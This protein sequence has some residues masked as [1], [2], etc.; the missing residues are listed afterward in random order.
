VCFRIHYS[1]HPTL[2]VL[3][4]VISVTVQ[5]DSAGASIKN[6]GHKI[7]SFSFAPLCASHILL[8]ALLFP[9]KTNM[10]E[11]DATAHSTEIGN[12]TAWKNSGGG[13]FAF[14]K[15]GPTENM[16]LRFERVRANKGVLLS[17]PSHPQ[18]CL[19]FSAL[20]QLKC[21]MQKGY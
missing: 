5:K 21:L 16:K 3:Y 19:H 9:L 7:K 13:F 12:S 4:E 2:S 17:P 11:A 15:P 8:P 14:R 6:Y 18:A 1:P 20:L 10:R